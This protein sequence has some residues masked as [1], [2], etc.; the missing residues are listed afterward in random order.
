ML[1]IAVVDDEEEQINCITHI[2]T[3]F[4]VGH[5][6][7]FTFDTYTSGE[8]L[9]TDKREYDLIFLDI[10][11]NGMDGIETAQRLRV[12]NKK[13][14]LFYVTS[15]RELIQKSMTIHPFAFIVKPYSKEEIFDNLEDYL[16][17]IGIAAEKE[18]AVPYQIH[19]V[20]DRILTIDINDIIY[21][22]CL[23]N[24]MI[25]I[26]TA[27][28]IYKVKETITNIYST[29]DKSRF[30]IPSRSFIVALRQI[31]EVD[32]KNKKF[33]MSNDDFILIPRR[34]FSDVMDRLNQYI[35]GEEGL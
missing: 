32:S 17:Y 31:K 12:Y 1:K 5:K 14:T 23:E 6:I 24:K 28:E 4:C 8:A 30:I 20:D 19:T 18:K 29:I 2:I 15:Y 7:E 3:E 27:D 16:S 33:I 11:M 13:V 34:K 21:F 22:R 9:L 35:S 25:D 10:Q 26:V